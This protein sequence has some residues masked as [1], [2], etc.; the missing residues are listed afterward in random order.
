MQYLQWADFIST[1]LA[2]NKTSS[3]RGN[4]TGNLLAKGDPRAMF[5]LGQM[6]YDDRNYT[7]A[8]IWFKRAVEND[9]AL[10]LFW[11]G[12]LY[13]RGKGV[14]ENRKQAMALF[15]Q[16]ASRKVPAA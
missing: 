13:W 12:K 8:E 11:L 2:L 4:G 5:S 14:L 9:H 3:G 1:V 6:A 10:S 15:Q 7:D 16:A